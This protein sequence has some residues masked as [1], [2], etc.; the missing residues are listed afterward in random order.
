MA[1]GKAKRRVESPA[2]P[3]VVKATF[4]LPRQ[5]A[6]RLAVAAAMT[7]ESQ[8]AITSR[9][10]AAHLAGWRLPSNL[11]GVQLGPVGT[12]RPDEPDEPAGSEPGRLAG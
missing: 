7:G 12:V 4:R 5:T 9:V 3:E 1:G 8:S 6:Q 10:L 2:T 11:G